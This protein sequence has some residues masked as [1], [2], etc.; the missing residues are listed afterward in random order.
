MRIPSVALASFLVVACHVKPVAIA[1]GCGDMDAR[2]PEL[3]ALIPEPEDAMR[4]GRAYLCAPESELPDRY[5]RQHLAENVVV[6]SFASGDEG[7]IREIVGKDVFRSSVGVFHGAIDHTY[8]VS[9]SDANTLMLGAQN[10]ACATAVTIRYVGA[11][12][13][14]SEHSEACD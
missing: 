10:E 3:S 8:S 11:Q 12:W 14:V 2:W 13:L 4:L 7:E 6:T 5:V 9:V 1:W